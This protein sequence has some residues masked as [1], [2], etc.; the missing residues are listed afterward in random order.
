[1]NNFWGVKS[2]QIVSVNNF[3]VKNNN[4]WRN[5]FEIISQLICI[6]AV[7]SGMNIGDN[8]ASEG[9]FFH[10]EWFVKAL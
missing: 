4:V 6:T 1:V 5:I 7:D 3:T 10:L 8:S 2:F 9:T